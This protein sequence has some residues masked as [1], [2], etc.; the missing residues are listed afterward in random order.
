MLRLKTFC[1]S[2]NESNN[3]LPPHSFECYAKAIRQCLQPFTDFLL[4]KDQHFIDNKLTGKPKTAMVLF[5]E[6]Q[7]F[8]HFLKH[9]YSIH[10]T[11][12][13]DYKE[14]PRKR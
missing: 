6:M 1:S 9:L 5:L 12:V 8:F 2:V 11:C 7:P 10:K 3:V 13:L 4:Q 14:I